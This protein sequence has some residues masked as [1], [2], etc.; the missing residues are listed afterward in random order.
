MRNVVTINIIKLAIFTITIVSLAS[1]RDK[2]FTSIKTNLNNIVQN[3]D[4]INGLSLIESK[5][6]SCHSISSNSHDEIIAPP[7]AAVKKRYLR[8][9]SEKDKFVKAISKW[10]MDPKQENALMRGA[11]NKFNLMPNLFIKEK[12]AIIIATYIFENELNKPT[13]F[14]QHFNEEHQAGKG[15]GFGFKNGNGQKRSKNRF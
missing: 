1:C 14:Q 8:N 12:E 7:L 15:R 10:V 13:W 11:V 6:Y 5:C 2:S 3:N 4:T 9:Y